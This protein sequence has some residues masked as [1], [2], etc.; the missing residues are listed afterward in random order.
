MSVTV[1]EITNPDLALSPVDLKSVSEWK[2]LPIKRTCDDNFC[3]D[4]AC[5]D[6]GN[7]APFYYYVKPEDTIALQFQL[8]DTINADPANPTYGWNSGEASWWLQMQ[9]MSRDGTVLWE[10]D[11]RDIANFYYVGYH[12]DYGTYQNVFVS[13]GKL[14][15][16]IGSDIPC[17]YF[18]VKI[19][20]SLPDYYV[21][22]TMVTGAGE[23]AIAFPGDGYT[24]FN[25]TDG[26]IYVY[27]DG[28]WSSTAP[29]EGDYLYVTDSGLWFLYTT[30][31]WS[32]TTAPYDPEAETFS[33]CS[34]H[35]YK[36]SEV[37]RNTV[38]L[39]ALYQETDCAGFIYEPPQSYF[40]R[41]D[42]AGTPAPGFF[43]RFRI[44]AV[45][46]P[47]ALPV[48]R[49]VTDNGRFVR[50]SSRTQYR[51]ATGALTYAAARRV[52]A[53]FAARYF[54]L[55]FV[56]FQ[57]VGELTKNNEE[58]EAWYIETELTRNECE[59]NESC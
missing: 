35:L 48:D 28:A 13:V 16:E 17:F 6:C 8:A 59:V 58:G 41:S 56:E 57:D 18:R 2:P 55:D 42:D 29:Q 26:L 20:E 36:V 43:T 4:S 33:Y 11:I 21:A 32:S 50:S 22:D 27:N 40:I 14:Q 10:G 19:R 15:T 25:A 51:F 1:I 7:D 53:V 34:T 47:T 49:E 31:S 38:E 46:E 54:T 44:Q 45:L 12:E 5:P 9:V 39:Y 3:A 37:C 23:P 24:V 30:G 52:Q